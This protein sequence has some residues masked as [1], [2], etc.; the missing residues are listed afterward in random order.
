MSEPRA[1]IF[2]TDMSEFREIH[3]EDKDSDY[4]MV[5]VDLFDRCEAIMRALKSGALPTEQS[6]LPEYYH[7]Y[8]RLWALD[9]GIGPEDI[10]YVQ[11]DYGV[12]G[13]KT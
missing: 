6:V 4:L 2:P 8:G 9:E 3:K 11:V 7:L 10:T 5:G 12:Y 13:R 1:S